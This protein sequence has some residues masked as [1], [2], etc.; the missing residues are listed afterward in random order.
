MNLSWG[1]T[2]RNVDAGLV[3]NTVIRIFSAASD[4]F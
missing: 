2:A 1:A 4:F 3:L